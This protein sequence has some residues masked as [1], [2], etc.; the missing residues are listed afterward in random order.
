MENH[1]SIK[2]EIPCPHLDCHKIFEKYIPLTNHL[3]KIHGHKIEF[4]SEE[5]VCGG[6]AK[7]KK[8][9][10]VIRSNIFVSKICVHGA[11]GATPPLHEKKFNV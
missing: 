1:S 5:L 3:N 4:H 8:E 9:K 2:R 7:S 6:C 10:K 11:K